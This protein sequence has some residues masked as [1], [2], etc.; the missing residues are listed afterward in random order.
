[1]VVPAHK[2]FDNGS[3]D[4]GTYEHIPNPST[5]F[6]FS[7]MASSRDDAEALAKAKAFRWSGKSWARSWKLRDI[8]GDI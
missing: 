4:P 1:M 6:N 5:A 7:S 8:D 2:T 3:L